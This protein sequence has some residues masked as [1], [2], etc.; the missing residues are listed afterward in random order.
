MAQ[1]LVLSLGAQRNED[2]GVETWKLKDK[3]S[4]DALDITGWT[5]ELH[6]ATAP[7]AIPSLIVN[8]TANANGS[9][10]AVSEGANGCFDIFIEAA[11]IAALPGR[12]IDICNLA[13]NLL[14]TDTLGNQHAYVVGP[15]IVSPGV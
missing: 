4:G 11:D 1:N 5:F 2:Y 8:S 15:F 13:Y 3:Q 12:D 7:G 10:V 14:M 6:I 9:Y